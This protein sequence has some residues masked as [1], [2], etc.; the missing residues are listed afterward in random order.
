M[1]PVN[2]YL[3]VKYSRQGI[4]SP[5]T[6]DFYSSWQFIFLLPKLRDLLDGTKLM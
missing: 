6:G 2:K 4:Y 5:D 1:G 3:Q